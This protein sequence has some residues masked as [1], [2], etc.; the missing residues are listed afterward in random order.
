VPPTQWT[1]EAYAPCIVRRWAC[2]WL[3]SGVGLTDRSNVAATRLYPALDGI[4]ASGELVMFEFQFEAP[5]SGA[6]L[7]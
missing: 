4:A 7:E 6:E 3:F 1:G 2:D 5:A